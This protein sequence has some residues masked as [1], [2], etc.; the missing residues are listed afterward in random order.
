M[1]GFNFTKDKRIN[2][3]LNTTSFSNLAANYIQSSGISNIQI[4][5]FALVYRTC[6]DLDPTLPEF[7]N[8]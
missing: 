4:S 8:P 3:Y 2:W 1:T 7:F 6:V 5:G